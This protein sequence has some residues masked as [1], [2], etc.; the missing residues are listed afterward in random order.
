MRIPKPR[1]DT[2]DTS[3]SRRRFLG[4]CAA[5]TLGRFGGSAAENAAGAGLRFSTSSNHFK[6]L[7]LDEVCRRISAL[8]FDGIDIWSAYEG[9]PHL[10]DAVRRLGGDGLRELLAKHRLKLCSFSCYVGGFAKYAALLGDTGGGVAIQGSAAP[11]PPAELTSKMR[12]FLESLK[13]L[14]EMA[15]R[16]QS[17]LAIENHG[18]ALLDSLDSFKA[19]VDLNR[20]PY[21]GIA[22]APYHLQAGGESV[23]SAI[24][25]AGSQLFF[26]YAWQHQ[27]GIAQLPGHGPTDF[28]PWLGALGEMRYP[29]YVNPFMHGHLDPD[30]MSAA[31]AVAL[32]Y[33]KERIK[34]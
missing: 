14:V 32:E 30:E 24:R 22:L 25:I 7:P 33:L 13:P 15:E 20:S 28:A 19:F 1:R 9:C 3:V 27:S 18:T 21:L 12:A 6:S 29:G 2:I 34:R 16:H 5:L 26:F 17:K 8:G 11:C 31:L 23:E 10:D 4:I